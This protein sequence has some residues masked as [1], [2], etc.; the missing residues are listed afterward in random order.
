MDSQR[1]ANVGSWEVDIATRRPAGRIEWYRI[2]GLPRDARPDFQ[3]FLSCVHPKDREIVL[4]AETRADSGDAPFGVE[5]RIIRPDGDS[6]VYP[7]DHRGDQEQRGDLVRL[8]GAAQDVT[9]QVK[10]TE[11]LRESE[12]R[13]KAPSA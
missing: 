1:L 13:L 12:A 8:A 3:T 11:L 2:F 5:F 4:E 6:A 10:A 9:E 7:L